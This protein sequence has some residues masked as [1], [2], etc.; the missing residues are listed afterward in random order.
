VTRITFIE[1]GGVVH[2]IDAA[3]GRSVMQIAQ[4][5][6]ITGILGDCGGN[7]ACGT[8]HVYVDFPWLDKLTPKTPEELA[9]LEGV[10]DPQ[11]NSR[12]TCQITVEPALAGLVVRLPKSQL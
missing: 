12:L 2:E 5:H 10:I 3:D 9:M 7:C 6:W 8:C 11:P 1:A 4:D